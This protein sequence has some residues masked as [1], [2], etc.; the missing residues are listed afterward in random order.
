MQPSM[1]QRKA[2]LTRW[3][4]QILARRDPQTTAS[5]Q[6]FIAMTIVDQSQSNAWLV[7]MR[8]IAVFLVYED[9]LEVSNADDRLTLRLAAYRVRRVPHGVQWGGVDNEAMYKNLELIP[10]QNARGERMNLDKLEI[11]SL[12]LKLNS[13]IAR[14][15]RYPRAPWQP[16]RLPGVWAGF[17][18]DVAHELKGRGPEFERTCR[19][20][21]SSPAHVF[22]SAARLHDGLWLY[23]LEWVD[24][25]LADAKAVFADVSPRFQRCLFRVDNLPNGLIGFQGAS[26]FDFYNTRLRHSKC[27]ATQ[28][29]PRSVSPAPC[30]RSA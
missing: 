26:A 7:E 8:N 14:A 27:A 28:A 2:T 18:R 19:H 22:R 10:R 30:I 3:R 6:G 20:A 25:D 17:K 1:P 11:A 21:R 9:R 24:G 5:R 29:S 13:R 15:S 16:V 4:R 23:P 12:A